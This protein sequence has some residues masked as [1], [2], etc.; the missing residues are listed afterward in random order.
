MIGRVVEIA[1]DDRHLAVSRGFLTV[2]TKGEEVGRVPLDD[3]GV[4][5]A[6]AHGLTYSNNLMVELAQRGAAVVLCG[7]NH[8]PVA[9]LW[10]MDGHHVQSLRMRQQ[11]GAGA[12]LRKRLWQVL[13]RAK[14]EQQRSVLER[15]GKPGG[16]FDLLARKVKSG[17]PENIEAQAARRYWPLLMGESFRRDRS[18]SGANAMLNYGYTV[19][20]AGV[21][22]AVTSAGLHPSVG[23][24]HNNRNNPMCL[25][26]DLMEPFRPIVDYIV[27]QLSAA[28]EDEV[29]PKTKS[30]LAQVLAFDMATDQGTTPVST[31]IERLTFSLAQSFETG[32]PSL[33]LP[34][35][36][37]PLEMPGF[38]PRSDSG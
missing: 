29:N 2:S 9:W 23:L 3:I 6:H 5:L 11:L 16:A 26:D 14:I 21:A 13:V 22:R 32:K 4:L 25:V 7:P 31:C 27:T 17:D 15:F 8:M 19:L 12:P 10:P 36:L 37:L 38:E 30:I 18:A 20:R 24:H 33:T 34:H 35:T 28:G 1:A